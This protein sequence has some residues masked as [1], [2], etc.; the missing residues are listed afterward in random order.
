M[1][2][3]SEDNLI[4]YT[5]PPSDTEESKLTNAERLVNKAIKDDKTLKAM[6]IKVFG[7]GSYANDTNVRL[8]SD[9][10]I[11]VRF[12][13]AC[14]F[15]L[16]DGKKQSDFGIT[17]F[18]GITFAEYKNAVENALVNQF[19]RSE[20]QRYDK[21]ITVK[22]STSRVETDVVPTWSYVRY[23][24]DRQYIEGVKFFSDKRSA[25]VNFP[26]LHL[27]NARVKNQATNKRFKR[28]TRIFRRIRYD[29]IDDK[30]LNGDLITSFLVECLVYNVPDSIFNQNYNWT[31]RLI[32]AIVFL[33]ENTTDLEKCDDWREVSDW[34]YLFRVRKWTQRDVNSYLV[35]MWNYLEYGS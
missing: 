20:V 9:I 13:D 19:G 14:Y 18:N 27:A 6:T 30:S 8:N 16:P 25:V 23:L 29:M 10:D 17:P 11:N 34:L 35:K 28:L 31:D 7:Q 24:D 26:L 12:D 21:C 22:E 3:L 33:F 32:Q 15:D 4:S 5:K 1:P 2:K